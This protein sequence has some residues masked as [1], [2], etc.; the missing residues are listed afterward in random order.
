MA[1]VEN[2]PLEDLL[3]RVSRGQR[4]AVLR[5][6]VIS[7]AIVAVAA[8]FLWFTLQK[9]SDAQTRLATVEEHIE[10]AV[11]AQMAAEEARDAAETQR[12]TAEEVKAV[13]E[14]A[15]I[16]AEGRLAEAQANVAQ[17]TTQVAALND[18]IGDLQLKLKEALNLEKHIYQLNWD[19]LKMIAASSGSAYQV[20]EVIERLRNDVRWGMS[21]T[22]EG[23][24]NSPGF[25]RFVWQKLGRSP[26]YEQLP[27]DRGDPRPGDIV[28]Y[29]SGY[30]MYF[31]L[32]YDRKPFVVG[33]TPFGVAALN[34]DFGVQQEV[35]L[36][37]RL[38][39]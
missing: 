34:Y 8:V 7:F 12:A 28:I 9:L 22:T 39:N 4:V 27:R 32:D 24:F 23:G 10:K 6:A 13:A 11:A 15:R 16:D 26:P 3:H 35:V 20:I 19:D 36:R 29:K 2:A 17:L 1:A 21:N 25:A 18:Q 33:M 38:E 37:T 14:K 31:F 5:T 30:A